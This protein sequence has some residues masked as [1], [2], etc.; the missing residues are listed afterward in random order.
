M[1][2]NAIERRTKLRLE[3]EAER[4]QQSLE[5]MKLEK[6]LARAQTGTDRS[7]SFDHLDLPLGRTS[8]GAGSDVAQG[9]IG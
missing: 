1:N 6:R 8:N 3:Y 9:G 4:Q 5:D 2:D 7:V